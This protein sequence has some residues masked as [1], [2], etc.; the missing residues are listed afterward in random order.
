MPE[1][2]THRLSVLRL[3]D[4]TVEVEQKQLRDALR[5]WFQSLVQ[6]GVFA[7]GVAPGDGIEPRPAD[8]L[9]VTEIL[10]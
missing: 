2:D 3:H 1:P 8:L 10:K 4:G 5:Q 7:W 6:L 9:A